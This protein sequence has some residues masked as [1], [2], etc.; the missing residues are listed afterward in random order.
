MCS[1]SCFLAAGLSLGTFTIRLTASVP[2]PSQLLKLITLVSYSQ[3]VLDLFDAAG[4]TSVDVYNFHMHELRLSE[5][6]NFYK[7]HRA[8]FHGS[9]T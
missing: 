5:L 8:A 6:Q 2:F 7:I 3:Q 4:D 1:G 9:R